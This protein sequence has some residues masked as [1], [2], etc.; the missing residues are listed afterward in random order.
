M[1]SVTNVGQRLRGY[2]ER[3][4]LKMSEDS[5][6]EK[7]K[8]YQENEDYSCFGEYS[9]RIKCSE[10]K[11]KLA[12]K[13]FTH[14]KQQAIYLKVKTKYKGRGKYRRKDRY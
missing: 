14:E 6:L 8:L 5:T 4:D 9:S 3:E 12:C 11:N 2:I 13:N 7:E 1:D 10:C